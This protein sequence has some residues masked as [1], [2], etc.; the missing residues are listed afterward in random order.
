VS[1]RA[2]AAG[3]RGNGDAA[4]V[5]ERSGIGHRVGFGRRPALVVVDLQNGFTDPDCPVGGD[6]DDVI[7]STGRLLVEARRA[8]L[9]IAFTAVGFHPYERET[10]TWLRKMPGLAVLEDGSHWC[11]IDARVAPRGD[12]PVYVKRA[13]S[14]FF[15]TPLL[16][17]LTAN[18]VDTVIVAGCVTSGCVRATT[19]DAVSWGL[20]PIV[21]EECVGDRAA[22]P[23]ATNLFDIDAKYADVA[24]LAEVI[25]SVRQVA[26]GPAPVS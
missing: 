9:P 23:H 6:L 19:I 24:P 2:R 4:S 17:L 5:Y 25:S 1:D 14:A 10:S 7:A 18:R 22:G 26:A 13:S 3:A 12:E 20:R 16:S 11:G 21:P 15:G 8:R